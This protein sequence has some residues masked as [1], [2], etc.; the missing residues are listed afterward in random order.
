MSNDSESHIH[1]LQTPTYSPHSAVLQRE[2]P[3]STVPT[4]KAKLE[5]RRFN[6]KLKRILRKKR[7]R[8]NRYTKIVNQCS[9]EKTPTILDYSPFMLKIIGKK[10]ELIVKKN[11]EIM[12]KIS[13]KYS[14]IKDWIESSANQGKCIL[15]IIFDKADLYT[16]CPGLGTPIEVLKRWLKQITENTHYLFGIKY[17]IL[18]IDNRK[19]RYMKPY[20]LVNFMW[21]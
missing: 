3:Q 10:N 4:L 19:C 17:S 2:M 13:L 5:D 16:N 18:F 1:Y 21:S 11:E 20:F 7:I 6:K 9:K 12:N 15:P 14:Y 8:E